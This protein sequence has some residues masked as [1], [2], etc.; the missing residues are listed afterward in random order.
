[1]LAAS[2]LATSCIAQAALG[3]LSENIELLS[4]CQQES[5]FFIDT[6]IFA[7]TTRLGSSSSD[8]KL[9]HLRPLPKKR[10][11]LQNSQISIN[12]QFAYCGPKPNRGT[13][14]LSDP[15]GLFALEGLALW[16]T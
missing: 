8:C 5:L 12:K 10:A 2:V 1:V 16:E 7:I 9:A 4:G 11:Q 14:P 6:Y 15:Y 3:E 13:F